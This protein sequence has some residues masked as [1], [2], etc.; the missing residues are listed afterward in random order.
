MSNSKKKIS[1]ENSKRYMRMN[2]N[3]NIPEDFRKEV[4]HRRKEKDAHDEAYYDKLKEKGYRETNPCEACMDS[5]VESDETNESVIH[6]LINMYGGVE[7]LMEAL[8]TDSQKWDRAQE[9]DEKS[10]HHKNAEEYYRKMASNFE[11]GHNPDGYYGSPLKSKKIADEMAKKY[12]WHAKRA[13]KWA[14]VADLRLASMKKKDFNPRTDY[15]E[16][17]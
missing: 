6:T 10:Y 5:P 11:D 14:N 4:E 15:E 3:S 9:N 7:N 17:D 1:L 2:W 8:T 12:K 13:R 16:Y